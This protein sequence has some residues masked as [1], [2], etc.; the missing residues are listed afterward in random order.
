MGHF[1]IFKKKFLNFHRISNLF[2][3]N[4][5]S[6]DIYKYLNNNKELLDYRLELL[7]YT[8]KNLTT[9]VLAKYVVG[10]LK[11]N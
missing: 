10:K 11:I 5:K 7:D 3:Y 4:L 9:E 1:S 6:I 8:K 2:T